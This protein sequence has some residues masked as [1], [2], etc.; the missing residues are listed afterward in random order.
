[1]STRQSKPQQ[2]LNIEKVFLI[3]GMVGLTDKIK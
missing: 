1:M 3:L 2:A